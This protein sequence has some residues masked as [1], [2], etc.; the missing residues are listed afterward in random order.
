MK[1]L[2]YN[3]NF[4]FLLAL[5]IFRFLLTHML[6]YR[7]KIIFYL[8]TSVFWRRDNSIGIATG[9]GLDGRRIWVRLPEISYIFFSQQRSDRLWV[10]P[11]LLYDGNCGSVPCGGGGKAVK[12]LGRE[13]YHSPVSSAEVNA[14]SYTSTPSYVSI[15]YSLIKHRDLSP[16]CTLYVCL[17][18]VNVKL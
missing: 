17:F 13:V 4:K 2:L 10:P 8:D 6:N 1:Y 7:D 14:R 12:L 3:F 11:S 18:L 15:V 9:Y 5:V 16:T